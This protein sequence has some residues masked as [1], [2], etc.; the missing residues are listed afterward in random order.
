[1]SNNT[2]TIH[3]NIGILFYYSLSSCWSYKTMAGEKCV[4][5]CCCSYYY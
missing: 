5:Y 1:M 3:L 4:F 2:V